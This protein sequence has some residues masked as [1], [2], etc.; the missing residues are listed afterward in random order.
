MTLRLVA[1]LGNPG[2]RY[3]NTRHN[4]GF[5]VVEAL[6]AGTPFRVE[7]RFNSE[8]CRITTET[9]DFWILKPLTFM[10]HSGQAIAAWVNYYQ[11][12]LPEI[13]V[14]HDEIDLPPGV[15]RIKQG[16]GNGGHNGL[17]DI[18]SH[19]GSNFLRIRIGIGHPGDANQVVN[20]VLDRPPPAEEL[21]I[22]SAINETLQVFPFIYAG[23]IQKA[24]NYLHTRR[25]P[26]L[27]ENTSSNLNGI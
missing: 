10:N 15:A 23:E 6:A 22:H 24:M 19:L 5:W 3:A 14:I 4:A 17:R 21:A 16:G 8:I 20:Y 9:T 11:T 1:G 12:P 2:P 18:H 7:K 13:I 26:P 25:P 27:I